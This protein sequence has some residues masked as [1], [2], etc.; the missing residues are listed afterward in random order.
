MVDY[1]HLP[2]LVSHWWTDLESN[3]QAVYLGVFLL[4]VVLLGVRIPW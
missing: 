2:K 4:L 3:W 1:G